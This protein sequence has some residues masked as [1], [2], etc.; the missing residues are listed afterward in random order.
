MARP[1]TIDAPTLEQALTGLF[2]DYL[3]T[4]P[5]DDSPE[6]LCFGTYQGVGEKALLTGFGNVL[7]G[8]SY[9]SFLE[10]LEGQLEEAGEDE[11]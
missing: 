11:S 8:T 1:I 9:P 7:A 4:L 2:K 6:N 3:E 10:W 5:D